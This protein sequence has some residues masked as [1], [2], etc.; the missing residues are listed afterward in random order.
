MP[1]IEKNQKSRSTGLPSGKGKQA[2][3]DGEI[4]AELLSDASETE[5][6]EAAPRFPIVGVGA[7][8]GGLEAFTKLLENLPP[9]T[10]APNM[11]CRCPSLEKGVLATL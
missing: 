2:T 10:R 4:A 5:D 7:S 6:V 9:N 3:V 11:T 1:K 8:A